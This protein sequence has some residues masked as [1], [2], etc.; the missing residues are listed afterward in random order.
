MESIFYFIGII[1]AI[2]LAI[3]FVDLGHR[4]Q[5]GTLISSGL[6]QATPSPASKLPSATP[7]QLYRYPRAKI[8]PLCKAELEPHDVLVATIFD[9]VNES[10]KQRVLIHGCK[11]CHR[12]ESKNSANEISL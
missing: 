6:R 2:F 11:F 12:R 3:Y 7:K 4:I 1:F 8:C 9:E 5:D 10:G